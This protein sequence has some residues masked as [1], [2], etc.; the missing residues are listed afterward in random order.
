[1][2]TKTISR[3]AV[4]GALILLFI[5]LIPLPVARANPGIFRVEVNGATSGSCGDQIDW[6]NPCDLQYALTT[7]AA[8]GDELWVASGTYTPTT[9]TDRTVSFQLK[10]GVGLYGGFAGT[11]TA[12]NQRNIA[13]NLTILSGDIDHND[14]ANPA[15]NPS[16][17][18]GNNSYHVVNGSGTDSTAVLDGFTVTGGNADSDGGGMYNSSGSPTVTNV[19][20]SGNSAGS[21]GGGMY[22]LSSSSPTVTNVTFSGNSAGSEGGG[23]FNV[24]Q[25]SPM[26]T[27]VTFSGNSAG[28]SGGGI[29][30]LGLSNATL[31]NVTFSGNS[32]PIGGGMYNFSSG[33]T[34]ANVTFSGNS[35]S[36]LYSTHTPYPTVWNSIVWGNLGPS[37][38][39]GFVGAI[40]VYSSIMQGGYSGVGILDADPKLSPLSN[41]GGATQTMALGSGSAAINA[42][43]PGACPSTDQR[44]YPRRT[45]NGFCDMGAYEAQSYA[46]LTVGSGGQATLINSPFGSALQAKVLDAN[47]NLLGG[48]VVTY[49]VPASGASANLATNSIVSNASGVIST[50]ATANGTAGTY[51]V[52]ANFASGAFPATWGLTNLKGNTTTT[53]TSSANPSIV[54]NTV[55]FTV[56]VTSPSGGT[57]TGT[58]DFY[59]T[60]SPAASVRAPHKT[61]ASSTLVGGVATFTASSLT[62]GTH[63]MLA[64]YS[65]D[66]NYSASNSALYPQ[67]VN[68]Q[69]LYFY[70]PWVAKSP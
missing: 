22:N 44:G 62:V 24:N 48:V 29:L 66:A 63:N 31:T 56:T 67:V 6:S 26:L 55:T 40:F 69:T 59:E 34:L 46:V 8:S 70:L 16:Q 18:V 49:T 47:S 51:N 13:A 39:Q 60:T 28:G 43:D 65:G 32:A 9:G 2:R 19:T 61:L 58:V 17:I 15:T 21:A 33:S 4:L 38:G 10:S 57:P 53:I 14:T 42:A 50:T 12:R 45:A 68:Y 54:G 11:E 41:N 35:V 27:N 37:G 36:A 20:F 25:S 3:T 64:Q 1:M 52:V 5:L 7:V 23:M 30:N